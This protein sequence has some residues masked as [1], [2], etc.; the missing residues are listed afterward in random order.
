MG[1]AN[2]TSDLVTSVRS[3]LTA[4]AR[5]SFRAIAIGG[6]ILTLWITV[7]SVLYPGWW[8]AAIFGGGLFN[9]SFVMG[10]SPIPGGLEYLVE[11]NPWLL[12]SIAGLCSGAVVAGTLLTQ[13]RAQFFKAVDRWAP[14]IIAFSA[15]FLIADALFLA[16]TEGGGDSEYWMRTLDTSNEPQLPVPQEIKPPVDFYYLRNL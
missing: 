16:R 6:A 9:L 1:E 3:A 10:E 13:R 2:S 5:W 15:F 8:L 4:F 7:G 11:Y 14:V 12:L